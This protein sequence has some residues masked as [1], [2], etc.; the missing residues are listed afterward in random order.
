MSWKKALWAIG[1]VAGVLLAAPSL[2]AQGS[3]LDVY[4]AKIKPE[5]T[6]DYTFY[7]D[8]D[9]GYRLVVNNVKLLDAMDT[10]RG[11]GHTDGQPAHPSRRR[12]H[13]SAPGGVVPAG[14]GWTLRCCRCSRS[15]SRSSGG[16]WRQRSRIRSRSSGLI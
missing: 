2:R 1:F 11:L 7:A 3:Y 14:G 5:F 8:T 9:D 13:L 15:R 4:I 6:G 10:R 16:I 12:P